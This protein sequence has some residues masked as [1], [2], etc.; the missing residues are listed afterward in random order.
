M[1][2][3]D[4]FAW[5]TILSVMVFATTFCSRGPKP[6][7]PETEPPVFDP[8]AAIEEPGEEAA[9][10]WTTETEIPDE[11]LPPP[12]TSFGDPKGVLKTIYFD[13]DRYNLKPQALENL[14]HNLS[15][16]RNNPDFEIRI[17]GHCDERGTDEY[18]LTL[19]DRRAISAREYLVKRGIPATRIQVISFGEER[20][21]DSRHSN[22]AWTKNR[23]AEFLI[24]SNLSR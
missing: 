19:G 23:R 24:V 15:W 18:N 12:G 10:G 21:V 20:P 5:V 3:S 6:G 11:S 13:F 4:R 7:S 9:E 8:P 22:S 17:E 2:R 16:L 14:N 1:N